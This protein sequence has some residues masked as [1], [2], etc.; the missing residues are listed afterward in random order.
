MTY[1]PF[2]GWRKRSNDSLQGREDS[3]DSHTTAGAAQEIR[4]RANLIV[5]FAEQGP[6]D[7]A[8]GMNPVMPSAE[9]HVHDRFETL[10]GVICDSCD[11]HIGVTGTLETFLR[12]QICG[13]GCF[14]ICFDC[15]DHG[16]SCGHT[17]HRLDKLHAI[18]N[19]NGVF[20]T[21]NCNALAEM[22]AQ[23]LY[24]RSAQKWK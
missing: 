12:C 14:D 4:N 17:D 7:S 6:R 1:S 21:A 8:E 18:D 3:S 22:E 10:A 13:E 20:V 23:A 15:I 11:G 16:R 19:G 9:Q 5:T 2:A 24:L